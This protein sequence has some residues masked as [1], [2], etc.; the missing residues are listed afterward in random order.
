MKGQYLFLLFL[1]R[2]QRLQ[3]L[4]LAGADLRGGVGARPGLDLHF[5]YACAGSCGEHRQFLQGFLRGGS[6]ALDG[7][8]W[9]GR[10]APGQFQ[11]NQN[12]DFL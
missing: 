12:R 8:G 1:C 7:G 5:G 9:T 10:A 3:L 2:N 4:N 6:F 11:A